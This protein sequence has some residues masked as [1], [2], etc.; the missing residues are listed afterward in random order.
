MNEEALETGKTRGW[1]ERRT[2][3]GCINNVSRK[4]AI[5]ETANCNEMMSVSR[6]LP[7]AIEIH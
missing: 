2:E 6:K 7:A 3:Q 1:V 4:L 5:V